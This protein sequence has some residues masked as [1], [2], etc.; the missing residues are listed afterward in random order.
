MPYWLRK[1]LEKA[2]FEKNHHEIVMLNQ[3][4]YSYLRK[5]QDT[6]FQS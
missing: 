5:N 2:Y 6:F 3:C 4:W 1:Q